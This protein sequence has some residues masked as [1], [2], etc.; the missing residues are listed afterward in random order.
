MSFSIDSFLN[1]NLIKQL[2][3]ISTNNLLYLNY[4]ND[5]IQISNILINNYIDSSILF[6]IST[7][8]TTFYLDVYY[9]FSIFSNY[10]FFLYSTKSL[11]FFK[12]NF[13]LFFF[14]FKLFKFYL[15]IFILYTI[16]FIINIENYIKQIKG[17]NLLTK[18]FLLNSTEK[19]VG[20]VDDYFFFA[21]LFFLTI[22][23]FIFTFISLL[24]IQNK[25]FI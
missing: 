2:I 9:T 7:Q 5:L 3:N 10:S 14:I 25:I 16:F 21:I 19:E 18:L 12:F 23:L 17:I 4:I 20:L 15:F 1:F 6:T 8:Y 22:S 11:Y 24:I 13:L